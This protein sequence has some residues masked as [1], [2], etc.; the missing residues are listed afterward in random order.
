M[1]TIQYKRENEIEEMAQTM[2][3]VKMTCEECVGVRGDIYFRDKYYCKYYV[4]ANRAF[5]AGYRK[6]KDLAKDILQRIY[7]NANLSWV[8]KN[9]IVNIGKEFDAEIE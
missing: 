8:E 9:Y 2:C 4:A 3:N 1:K 5:N 6:Q 7:D